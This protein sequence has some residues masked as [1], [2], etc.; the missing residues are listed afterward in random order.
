MDGNQYLCKKIISIIM[1]ECICTQHTRY[2]ALPRLRYHG[3]SLHHFVCKLSQF[4]SL[5]LECLCEMNVLFY[6]SDMCAIIDAKEILFHCQMMM[7]RKPSERIPWDVA[8]TKLQRVLLIC[9]MKS[10]IRK[11]A[12]L[13]IWRDYPYWSQ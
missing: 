10:G 11:N 6:I 12:M 4:V 13:Q 5:G 1:F 3:L 8:Q 7:D 2:L 9:Q